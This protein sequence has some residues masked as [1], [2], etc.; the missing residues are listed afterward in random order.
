LIELLVVIAI[1]A[2]LAALLL[3]ALSAA[4][5]GTSNRLA[6]SGRGHSCVVW[7]T[8]ECIANGETLCQ[9]RVGPSRGRPISAVG[10]HQLS[11]ESMR[12]NFY[13]IVQAKPRCVNLTAMKATLL[14]S[15]GMGATI[16]F[17]AGWLELFIGPKDF[18]GM[19]PEGTVVEILFWPGIQTG[20]AAY[21]HFHWPPLA[22]WVAGILTM[23]LI[24]ASLGLIIGYWRC[25]RRS[26]KSRKYS[27]SL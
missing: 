5:T 13:P 14:K 2:L 21:D 17:V 7:R 4:K 20:Q 9:S 23:S 8:Y 27:Q 3:P 18:L 6:R 26:G 11:I 15:S 10:R 19:R 25:R 1:I 12:L 16:A 24:G 22:C